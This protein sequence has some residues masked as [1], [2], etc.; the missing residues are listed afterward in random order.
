MYESVSKCSPTLLVGVERGARELDTPFVFASQPMSLSLASGSWVHDNV[1]EPRLQALRRAR[2]G[3]FSRYWLPALY[4]A[5][6]QTPFTLTHA[7]S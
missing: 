6:V 7:S 2:N 5:V 4:H 1:D 3:R